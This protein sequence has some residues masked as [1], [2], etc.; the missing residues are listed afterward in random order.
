MVTPAGWPELYEAVTAAKRGDRERLRRLID[1]P[2]VGLPTMLAAVSAVDQEFRATVVASGLSELDSA[3]NNPR[4][5][6]R[7][8]GPL[9]AR[10][11]QAALVYPAGPAQRTAFFTALRRGDHAPEGL[12]R[13]QLDRLAALAARAESVT[14]AYVLSTPQGEM[15]V[16][17][18]PITDRL[19]FVLYT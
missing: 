7:I 2:L 15:V 10:L 11:A 9:L 1:W 18:V 6:D 3:T 16:G 14:E 13:D 12:T 17:R 19:V 8:L 5:S 4:S